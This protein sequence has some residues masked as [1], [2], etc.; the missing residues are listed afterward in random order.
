MM[1]KWPPPKLKLKKL[2]MAE[3]KRKEKP[4]N[5]STEEHLYSNKMRH[6]VCTTG[7]VMKRLEPDY[8]CRASSVIIKV[9]NG[10]DTEMS[11]LWFVVQRPKRNFNGTDDVSVVLIDAAGHYI[12]VWHILDGMDRWVDG[13]ASY[14]C[15]QK[16]LDVSFWKLMLMESSADICA[17]RYAVS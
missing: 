14:P 4:L 7:E 6:G 11:E 2:K 16:L 8:V 17:G 5:K 10:V 9:F 15:T 13:T 3:F 1:T 12:E